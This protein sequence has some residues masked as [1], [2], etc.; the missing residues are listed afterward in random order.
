MEDQKRSQ[1]GYGLSIYIPKKI[2]PIIEDLEGHCGP[3]RAWSSISA[4]ICEAIEYY[5]KEQCHES[6]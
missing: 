3:G 6:G 5:Y 1:R 4:F 2:E